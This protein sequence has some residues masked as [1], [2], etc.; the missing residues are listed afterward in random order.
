MYN[1]IMHYNEIFPGVYVGNAAA[2]R[3]LYDKHKDNLRVVNCAIEIGRM[4]FIR[5]HNYCKIPLSDTGT[6]EDQS[7]FQ[8]HIQRIINFIDSNKKP[9]LI[10][11]AMGIS[12]SCSVLA[13]YL[14]V[15]NWRIPNALRH[16][17]DKR[18]IAFHSGQYFTYKPSIIFVYNKMT[19]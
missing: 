10:H 16:I 12:R 13:A 11:C 15:H 18:P 17:I 5:E 2:V 9:V 4:I 14:I 3:V 1:K 7:V 8:Q 19:G 6:P